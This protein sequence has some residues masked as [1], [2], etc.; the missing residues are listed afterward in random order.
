MSARRAEGADPLARRSPALLAL[1]RA[2]ARRYVRRH[3]HGVWV[4]QPPP[5]IAGP[6]LVVMNHPSWWDPR[7]REKFHVPSMG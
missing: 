3:F 4:Q 2:Y 5:A 6:V 1:F 7:S